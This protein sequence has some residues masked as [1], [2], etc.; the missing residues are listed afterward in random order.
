M[1][2]KEYLKIEAE[3]RDIIDAANDKISE[4]RE[5]ADR[6]PLPDN[7]RPAVAADIK[8]G[9][10]IWYPEWASRKNG[11]PGWAVVNEVGHHGD[12]FK[13]YTADDGCRYGLRGAFIEV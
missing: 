10:V 4:A 8:E 13:A 1:T 11:T 12:P 9:A 7:L 6:C 5:L 2:P 3:Q